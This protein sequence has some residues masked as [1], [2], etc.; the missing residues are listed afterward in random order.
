M[1]SYLVQAIPRGLKQGV[2]KSISGIQYVISHA[3]NLKHVPINV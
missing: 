1:Q 3:K 2:E